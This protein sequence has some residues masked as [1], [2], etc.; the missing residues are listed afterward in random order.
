MQAPAFLCGTPLHLRGGTAVAAPIGICVRGAPAIAV[1]LRHNRA[2]FSPVAVAAGVPPRSH[3]ITVLSAG[4]APAIDAIVDAAQGVLARAKGAIR[5]TRPLGPHAVELSAFVPGVHDIADLRQAFNA[6]GGR[7]G[8]DFNVQTG[9]A[10]TGGKRLAVF[11]LDSTLI[12]EE[13]IDE[14]AAEVGRADEVKAITRRAMNGEI[15]FRDALAERVALLKGLHIDVLDAVIGRVSF[16]PGARRLVSILSAMGCETAVISGGFEFLASHVARELELDHSFA[17]RLEVGPDNRLTGN[18]L[19]EIV[20]ADFK[21]NTLT[22][23]AEARGLTQEQIIA[24]GDGSNDIPMLSRAGL[25]VAFN[26]KPIVQ[27]SSPTRVNQASLVSVLY[28]LGL[29]DDDIDSAMSR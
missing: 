7:L 10:F 20:D 19:G 4:A 21:A 12:T 14:L 25:G 15:N 13:T 5:G 27:S 23:L 29:S 3:V 16:T 8:V 26:A 28:L 24:V 9:E 11:D 1:P 6:E 18:T 2:R 17:N 22:K